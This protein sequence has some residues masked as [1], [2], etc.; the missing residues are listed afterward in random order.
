MAINPARIIL[1]EAAAEPR[2]EGDIGGEVVMAGCWGVGGGVAQPSGFACYE[3]KTFVFIMSKGNCRL[4][5]S[6]SVARWTWFAAA[7]RWR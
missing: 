4:S 1:L 2:V 3:Y 5:D 7:R 6:L